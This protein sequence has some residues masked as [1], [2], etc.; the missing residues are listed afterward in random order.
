M[1]LDLEKMRAKIKAKAPKSDE[2]AGSEGGEAAEESTELAALRRARAAVDE[3]I[4]A[5]EKAK[6]SK[7]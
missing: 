6:G 1:P 7:Y 4:A 2:D 5:C 3:A